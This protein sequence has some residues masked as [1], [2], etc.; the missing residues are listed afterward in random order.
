[1]NVKKTFN[2]FK[3]YS[4]YFWILLLCSLLNEAHD[5]AFITS[6]INVV[7]FSIGVLFVISRFTSGESKI[8]EN[9]SKRRLSF[10]G[11]K[12]LLALTVFW[13]LNLVSV[14][15]N[16]Q[17]NTGANLQTLMYMFLQFYLI[18]DRFTTNNMEHKKSF[19]KQLGAVLVIF[20]MSVNILSLIM[21][22]LGIR[23]QVSQIYVIGF[24]NT[25]NRLWGFF[26][27]NA[28]AALAIISIAFSLYFIAYAN[29]KIAKIINVVNI[30]IQYLYIVLAHSRSALIG[31]AVFSFFVIL[32]AVYNF[33]INLMRKKFG[34]IDKCDQNKL[35]VDKAKAFAIAAILSICLSVVIVSSTFFI[36]PYMMRIPVDTD[37]AIERIDSNLNVKIKNKKSGIFIESEALKKISPER[38][39]AAQ[40]VDPN[41]GRILFWLETIKL[42]NDKPLLGVSYA[43]VIEEVSAAVESPTAKAEIQ[44]GGI[45]STLISI[46]GA[47]GFLGLIVF[48]IYF[49]FQNLNIIRMFYLQYNLKHSLNFSMIIIYALVI[50]FIIIDLVETRLLYTMNFM[51]IF[52]WFFM[53]ILQDQSK[54]SLEEEF[55][56]NSVL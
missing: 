56:F 48:L 10:S 46:V 25:S 11:D 53:G 15:I 34:D 37:S 55:V 30:V 2:E 31:L 5:Y 4:L 54:E 22:I 20:T 27:P 17:Y 28:G 52:F 7:V 16:H 39:T 29:R 36:R 18:Y 33:Q 44:A 12:E 26:N 9:S 1:M 42:L 23:V 32:A 41:R 14:F 45:H 50:A 3:I 35:S 19:F 49:F 6:T 43:G 51:S 47:S 40:L 24:D 38:S 8:Y 13:G 21:F